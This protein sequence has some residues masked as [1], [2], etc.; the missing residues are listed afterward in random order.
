VGNA[1]SYG[2]GMKVT[3]H[4]TL[5]DGLLDICI[6]SEMNKLKLFCWVPTIFFGKHLRLKQVEY[7]QAEHIRIEPE[8]E[9][10]VYADGEPSGPAPVEIGIL[11]RALRVMVPV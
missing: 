4:A 5:D 8:R 1:R 11:P 7:F 3:P 6:V 10:E 9:L 2:G